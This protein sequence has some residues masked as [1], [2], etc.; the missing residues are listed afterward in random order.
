MELLSLVYRQYRWPFIAITLLS[1]LSAVSGIGVIAFINQSLIESVGDPLPILGQLVGLVLLLLVITLGSQ[2]ALTTLGHHFV[3]R[4][5]GRL[6]KQLLDTDVARLRQIG[7]GPL[8]ASLSSDIGQIT[9]A[10]VRLPELVQGL[11]LTLGS[12]IYLGL[13]SPALLGVTA[14][15]V[16]VTMVVG[17]LLVNRV[18]RHLAHMR[19]AEDRLYQNYQSI[20]AGCKEL[21]LNRERAHF[22]YHQLYEQ[23]ARDYREQIIR[24]DTYHLSAVNWSN[25]MML[26]A[27]GLVFFLANGLGWANTNVAATFALTLLFLRTPLL[28][29]IGAL[30]TLIAAQVAFDKI[31]ALNLAEPDEA[32]PLPPAPRPWQRIELEQVSFHYQG[33]GGFSVGPI[34]LVIERGEQIFLIG[35]NG[36]GKSTL[37]MLLT[38]L[39]QPVSGRIL[40]DGEPVTDRNGYL[41]LFSAIFTDYHLFQ[42][43]L[44]PEPKEALVAEWLERL[45]MGSKLTIKDG[46]IADIDL[47]QGQRKR[48]A[49]LLALAEQ[50]EV[51]LFD[52]WAADQDP[53]FRRIFYQVL[54]PRLKEMGKTVIAISHDDHYFS[55]ADRLLEMRQGRLTE[56]TGEQREQVSRDAVAHL[57]GKVPA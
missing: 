8:L 4:L 15:W 45:Q 13:L 40:L 32:F 41:G 47:S 26:G 18:Y 5:R 48:V 52:E 23:N 37:A 9:I 16:T 6:L 1:L 21:A 20:I 28:Q 51:M 44:G 22:V 14:L 30:P 42:H 27:I 12:I 39:Y 34:N 53:Q 49:L 31:A 29:G 19:Q 17:W 25:I 24:A 7:Q 10:F 35:G 56:L 43:L 55:L 36:S 33:E 11:V 2:L 54:L 46:F 3:Y 50:R 57:D 38:G